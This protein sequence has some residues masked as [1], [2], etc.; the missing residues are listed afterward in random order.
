[1]RTF[2]GSHASD[3]ALWEL[4]GKVKKKMRSCLKGSIEW[5]PRRLKVGGGILVGDSRAFCRLW[6]KLKVCQVLEKLLIP[7]ILVKAC[8]HHSVKLIVLRYLFENLC[9]GCYI[10]VSIRARSIDQFQGIF[11]LR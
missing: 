10:I 5:R 7:K 3:G 6:N 11:F 1:M 2:V 4:L 9:K 8:I